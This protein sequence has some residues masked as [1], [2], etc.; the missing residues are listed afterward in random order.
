[1]PQFPARFRLP[2]RT[3]WV[4]AAALLAGLLLFLAMWNS[5]RQRGFYRVGAGA[6]ATAEGQ[7]DVFEPLPTPVADDGRGAA[8]PAPPAR[9]DEPPPAAIESPARPAPPP[10]RPVPPPATVPA[11]PRAGSIAPVPISQPA[12]RYPPA[13]LRQGIGGRVDVRVDIGPD[14]VPTS[15]SLVSGSGSRE[16]DRAALDAVRRWRFRP[17]TIDGLPSVGS[18]TV[19]IQF[20]AGDAR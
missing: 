3:P 14:G 13:A 15:V 4:M 11:A 6:P 10:S 5:D 9:T 12:P 19:P 17:A 8:L 1:M 18:V 2:R 16:L 20:T 7:V